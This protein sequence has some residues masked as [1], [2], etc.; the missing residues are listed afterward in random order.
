MIYI[1]SKNTVT[2]YEAPESI[3]T[4]IH[5][6]LMCRD[7]TDVGMGYDGDLTRPAY[8]QGLNDT[9]ECIRK[10]VCDCDYPNNHLRQ[11]VLGGDTLVKFFIDNSASDAIAKV[12]EYE[13]KQKKCADCKYNTKPAHSVCSS[14]ITGNRHDP[15][16]DVINI[17]DEVISR[18]NY[19]YIVTGIKDDTAYCCVDDNGDVA[20]KYFEKTE[21]KKTGRHFPQIE[22]VLKQIRG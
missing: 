7:D 22:E 16:D 1:H 13:E 11:S 3:E 18:S 9:W 15:I 10:I 21:L 4:A 20:P 12:K 5:N 6:L 17:G 8:E 14:C 19:Y 2:F